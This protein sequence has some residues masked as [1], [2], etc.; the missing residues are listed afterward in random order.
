VPVVDVEVPGDLDELPLQVDAAV[1]RLAQEALTNA[2]RHAR[3]ASRVEIRVVEAA[4]RL[5]LRVTDDGQIDPVRPPSHGFGLLG[6]TERVQL[7]GGTL[8]AGPAPGRGW[9]VD[10]ELPTKV[11]R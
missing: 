4:G 8:R 10:A 1:Y 11:R 5:R 6:M 9:T 3:N 2:L 7:L